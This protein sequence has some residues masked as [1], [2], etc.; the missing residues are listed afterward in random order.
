[1]V[2]TKGAKD[3]KQRVRSSNAQVALRRAIEK[4]GPRTASDGFSALF[5][6][7]AGQTSA[8]AVQSA[9]GSASASAEAGQPDQTDGSGDGISGDSDQPPSIDVDGASP[10]SF[11]AAGQTSAAAVQSAVGSA[12]AS[13][14]AGQPDQTDGSGDG[15]SGDS[16]QPPSIDVDGA[17]PASFAAAGQ[18][19]AAAVQS[20]VGSASA[21]A[22]A[23]QPDQTDG[24]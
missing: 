24:S 21:S 1:M 17:S 3:L 8:A 18:T 4:H 5:A 20:A 6:A 19:S 16:D 14:E 10:A 9:V 11:A 15:I 2:K 13:A 23:G 22:E 12:S 7:A